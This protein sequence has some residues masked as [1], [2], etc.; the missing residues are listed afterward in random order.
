M[1]DHSGY[2]G[3]SGHSGHPDHSGH[4]GHP[5]LDALADLHAGVLAPEDPAAAHVA[6]CERCSAEVAALDR[7]S[8]LLAAAG[9]VGPMPV[10]V[11]TAV[12]A[13]LS[14]EQVAAGATGARTVT[15]LHP[16][17]RS[18]WGMRVLQAAAVLVLVLAGVGIAVSGLGG[19]GADDGGASLSAGGGGN[20]AT[21]DKASSGAYPVTTSGRD[22]NPDAVTADASKLLT[23]SLAP[24]VDARTLRERTDS[25]SAGGD[26]D[27]SA[28]QL[29]SAGDADRLAAGPPLAECVAALADGPATPLAVDIATW[30]QQPAAVI[31]L[32]TPGDPS[33]ADVWVVAP[34]CG[35]EDA[36]LLYYANIPRP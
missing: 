28:P 8:G 32:P 9:P 31:L 1:S 27:E 12:D 6:A 3:Y 34:D 16:P 25:P 11:A 35:P 29:S 20:S 22:W 18:P 14:A 4:S 36:K 15:P 33:S 19:S 26:T 17:A 10:E 7:L 30:Q 21:Q 5:D 2:S 24:P 23:G 13:A